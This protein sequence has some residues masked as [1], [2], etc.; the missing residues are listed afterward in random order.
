MTDGDF[1][2]PMTPVVMTIS[3]AF[4]SADFIVERTLHNFL[5]LGGRYGYSH[6]GNLHLNFEA[7]TEYYTTT[8][9]KTFRLT[10]S[11]HSENAGR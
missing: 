10:L 3:M 5:S 11:A 7:T 9:P 8:S 6:L 2:D 4:D 1:I